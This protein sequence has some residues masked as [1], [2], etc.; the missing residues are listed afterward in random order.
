M[1]RSLFHLASLGVL[2]VAGAL[3]VSAGSVLAGA[4]C[5][6]LTNE[7]LLD[8]AGVFEAGDATVSTCSACVADECTA[9]W[10]MCLTNTSCLAIRQCA[11]APAGQATSCACQATSDGGLAPESL[12]RAFT[13]CSDA[14]TCASGC[15]IDCSSRCTDGG[16]LTTPAACDQGDASTEADATADGGSDAGDA[17]I[18]AGDA[19]AP[20]GPT[21]ESCRSCA[22]N[23]CGDSKKACA[24]GSECAAFLECTFACA[25]STC[26]DDC[27]RLHAT[28]KV[29]AVE[30]ATCT[31]AGCESEC[32]L[33]NR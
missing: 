26:V 8:D 29:A 3:A 15:A 13:T 9:A 17:A 23:K 7:A 11:A 22:S 27:G 19:G 1:M 24:I 20:A 5:T 10:A 30:L 14:R 28:G 4:G 32:G 31:Q 25:D 21:A 16:E 18:D 33:L 2:A 12:Y 6:V